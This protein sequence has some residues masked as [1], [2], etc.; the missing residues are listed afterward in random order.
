LPA[1]LA[2]ASWASQDR[3]MLG[4]VER[5]AFEAAGRPKREHIALLVKELKAGPASPRGATAA[6]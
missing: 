4:G 3:P 5:R 6:R 1:G 2:L